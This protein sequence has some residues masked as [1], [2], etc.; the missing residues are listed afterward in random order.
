MLY[1]LSYE[2]RD[3]ANGS[4]GVVARSDVRARRRHQLFGL[5][6]GQVETLT[7]DDRRASIYPLR[8]PFAGTII[9]NGSACFG[10][11][12]HYL[13]MLAAAA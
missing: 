10:P 12:N 8:A 3:G 13:G 5:S 9:F 11:S 2:G 4:G 7:Y 6:Q 1:P